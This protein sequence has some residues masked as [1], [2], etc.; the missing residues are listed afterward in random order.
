MEIT[1]EHVRGEGLPATMEE[2]LA[3]IREA[4]EKNTPACYCADTIEALAEKAGIDPEGLR[5][6]IDEYNGFC[7][8]GFDWGFYKPEN[9]L[10][11][12][13]SG[14][15]Y[16]VGGFLATDGAFG[17]VKVNPDMQAYATDGGLVEG[18]YVTGDFAS[19]RHVAAF[20]G[21]VKR[22]FINDLSWTFAGAYLVGDSAAKYLSSL[23]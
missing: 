17:G 10:M 9:A 22:Q 2:A 11:P 13:T 15:Y 1:D 6:T 21:L 20:D 16:A 23:S 8:E 4:A 14:P 19:G 18:L 3:D 7:A 5:Q 12:F